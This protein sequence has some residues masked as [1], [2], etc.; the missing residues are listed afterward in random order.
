MNR[1]GVRGPSG[2]GRGA[3]EGRDMR[4]VRP[5]QT[6]APAQE[7]PLPPGE[8]GGVRGPC[9]PGLLKPLPAPRRLKSSLALL[10]NA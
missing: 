1:P 7:L 8:G 10:L 2:V 6:A 9:S 3:A 5:P 4:R